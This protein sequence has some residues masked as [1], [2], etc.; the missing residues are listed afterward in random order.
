VAPMTGRVALPCFGALLR[1]QSVVYCGLMRNFVAPQLAAVAIDAAKR[2]E[3]E[4]PA[5]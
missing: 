1:S 4:F 2:V 3:A 5:R